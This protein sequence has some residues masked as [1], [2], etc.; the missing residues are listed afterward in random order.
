LSDAQREAMLRSETKALGND[1]RGATPPINTGCSAGLLSGDTITTHTSMTQANGI[2]QPDV[3]P[4]VKSL[5]DGLT[6]DLG[7]G[8]GKCGEVATLS[9]RMWKA[10][11]EGTGI[12]SVA[13][14]NGVLNAGGTRSSLY[15][16]IIGDSMDGK[17]AHG[18]HL[19]A[20]SS[21]AQV[22]P[23]LDLNVLK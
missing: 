7:K 15:T 1:A 4:A 6:N 5:Y 10:D 16:T 21:C 12:K 8:H 18:D 22:L 3:H 2:K 17:L 23:Q 13:D 14:M 9:D 20:C 11:P 19:P